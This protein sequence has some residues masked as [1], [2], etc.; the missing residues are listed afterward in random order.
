METIFA[1]FLFF[2]LLT[3]F[4]VDGFRKRRD[5]LQNQRRA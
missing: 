3:V 4:S 2:S 5:Y 1:T